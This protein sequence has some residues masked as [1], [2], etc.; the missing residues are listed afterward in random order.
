MCAKLAFTEV[1]ILENK[2]PRHEMYAFCHVLFEKKKVIQGTYEN[3]VY[4][5][6]RMCLRN[7][8]A[9]HLFLFFRVLF[10]DFIVR[11]LDL[12]LL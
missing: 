9:T 5:I 4:F 10:F 1:C 2:N 12:L 11:K 6:L 8:L 7:F 3:T